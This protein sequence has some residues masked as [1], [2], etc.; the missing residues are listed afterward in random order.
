[1][2]HWPPYLYSTMAWS[3]LVQVCLPL[4]LSVTI[5][6]NQ[7]LIKLITYS[8][9]QQYSALKNM[10]KYI[11]LHGSGSYNYANPRSVIPPGA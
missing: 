2:Y 3:R 4:A 8:H 11:P 1:M 10:E 9:V 5:I 6:T 7:Q